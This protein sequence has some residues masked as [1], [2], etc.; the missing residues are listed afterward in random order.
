[1]KIIQAFIIILIWSIPIFSIRKAYKKMKYEEKRDV[2]NELKNLSFLLLVFT[3]IG[4]QVFITGNI[5][6]IKL[7]QHIGVGLVFIG[8][9]SGCVGTFR[10]RHFKKGIG[11]ML[12]GA[13][14]AVIYLL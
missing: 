7:L 6:E 14:G 5:S 10:Q 13:V 1:M 2:K 9:V 4:F 3:C 11:L 8:F 12:A